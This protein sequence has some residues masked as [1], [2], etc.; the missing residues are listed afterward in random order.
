M[1]RRW[2]AGDFCIP[3]YEVWMSEAVARGRIS[4]P[5]FF[6]NPALRAAWLGCEWIGPSQGQLDPVKE[7]T[8]EILAVDYGFSTHS[9]STVKLNGGQWDVNVDALGRENERLREANEP[10]EGETRNA[11]GMINSAEIIKSVI[12]QEI[13]KIIKEE[14]HEIKN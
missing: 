13:A 5:G 6:T 2:F 4:A 7:I 1:R 10:R 8:A 11:E 9:Q 3:V 12:R 14:V